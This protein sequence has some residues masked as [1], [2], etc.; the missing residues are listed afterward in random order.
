MRGEFA[1]QLTTLG[2]AKV[3]AGSRGAR[4]LSPS[5]LNAQRAAFVHF[6]LEGFFRSIGLF[7]GDHLDEAKATGLFGMRVKHDGTLLHIAIF[8]E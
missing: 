1:E 6:T 3:F 8:L 2:R 7:S 5:L 4:A